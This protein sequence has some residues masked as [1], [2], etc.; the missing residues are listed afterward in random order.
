M[1]TREGWQVM[2]VTLAAI[3]GLV[4]AGRFALNPM[5]RLIAMTGAREVFVVGALLTVLGASFLMASFGLSMA[6]GAFI[7]G[8]MLADSPWRHEVEADIEPFRGLLLGLFFISVGMSLDLAVV[9]GNPGRILLFVAVLMLVK[10]VIIAV[11]ARAFGSAWPQAGLIGVHLSQGGEFAFIVLAAAT[12]GLLIAPAA[13]SLFTAVVVLSMA[14]T[15]PAL[16]LYER[17]VGH[18]PAPD[19]K[20]HDGPQGQPATAIVVGYGRYGQIVTQMLHARGMDVALIDTKPAQIERA[21]TFGWKVF[22]GDGFRTDVLRAAGAETAQLLLITAGG[23]WPPERL[24]PVRKA[25]PHLKILVRAHDRQHYMQLREH[26]LTL[27]VRELFHSAVETGRL[28]LAEIGTPA[29]R[30][31]AITREFVRR[32]RE[33][34]EAQVASGDL[35]AGRDTVFRP[36]SAMASSEAEVEAEVGAEAEADSTDRATE[37]ALGKPVDP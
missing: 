25:F 12:A 20:T 31:D 5:F 15:L 3:G 9:A 8:V 27:S 14:L 1:E 11:L 28:A 33:R 10:G 22:Y 26:D 7:A 36:G 19:A 29:E 17:L 35:M 13:A 16:A 18:G 2:L 30:I 34:L 32:D 21:A 24:A 6:M 4:L 23:A 37:P